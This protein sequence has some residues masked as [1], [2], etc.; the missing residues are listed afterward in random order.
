MTICDGADHRTFVHGLAE[1]VVT[2][3]SEVL[4]DGDLMGNSS[5]VMGN[6]SDVMGNSSDKCL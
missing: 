5:D 4:R 1:I 2:N 3:V 6:N